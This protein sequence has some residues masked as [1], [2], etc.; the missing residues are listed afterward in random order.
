[1]KV[2]S[3][4]GSRLY[5]Y[6]MRPHR[7]PVTI[8]ALLALA[9]V[10]PATPSLAQQTPGEAD[11][12]AVLYRTVL[13][14]EAEGEID[15]ADSLMD[16]ILRRYPDSAAAATIRSRRAAPDGRRR[17]GNGRTELIVWS[18]LYGL[19][20]G[21]AIPGMLGADGSEAYG[22]GLLL[23]GP[24][25]FG[26]AW[27]ATQDSPIT[28]G[29]AGIITWAGSWGTWQGFGWAHVLDV[30]RE[31]ETDPLP[32]QPAQCST[33]P[34]TE[35]TLGW[36]VGGGLAGAVAGAVA[37]HRLDIS[38]GDA[39][40][41][42]L[43]SLWGTWYG[44]VLTVLAD[45]EDDGGLAT[46]LMAG[47]IGAGAGALLARAYPVSRSQARIASIIGVAGGLA[48]AGIDLI[49][50]PDNAK[51]AIA[52]PAV[53][54]ALALGLAVSGIE[55]GGGARERGSEGGGAEWSLG[56]PLFTSPV[57]GPSG[58]YRTTLSLTLLSG[59]F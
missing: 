21:V 47:N 23:G 22:L 48:G 57:R 56:G 54:S 27:R 40:L 3:I 16:H 45:M 30:G 52:I 13:L 33:D 2:L 29:Q 9:L 20:L 39:T 1:M 11:P 35:A 19:W 5:T 31:C 37:A 42:N 51:V 59:T 53:T 49:V 14:L 38:P 32:G 44:F 17:E 10:L 46:T 4:P 18:T 36:M 50:Q 25:G 55:L 26:T 41:V 12:A 8:A 15:L 58:G 24:A 6:V 28:D 7:L 34:S 43:G